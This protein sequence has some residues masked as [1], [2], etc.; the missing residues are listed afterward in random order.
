MRKDDEVK[1]KAK[2]ITEANTM[3]TAIAEEQIWT[4]QRDMQKKGR[5]KK[6]VIRFHRRRN[7]NEGRQT[8]VGHKRDTREMDW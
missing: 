2:L 5:S 8:S 3:D 6:V 1:K 4:D 7:M